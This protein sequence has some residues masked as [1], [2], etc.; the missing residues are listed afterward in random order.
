M[1]TFACWCAILASALGLAQAQDVAPPPEP[2]HFHLGADVFY[3]DLSRL[4]GINLHQAGG[5]GIVGHFRLHDYY[6]LE[7]RLSGFAASETREIETEDGRH[8]KNDVTIVAMPLEADAVVRF[9]IG[10]RLCAY[11]GPGIG[12]YLFDG[13]SNSDL[14]TEKIVY[15]IEVDDE[16]GWYLLAGLRAKISRNFDLFVEGRY[17]WIKTSIEKAVEVRN[18]I[19]IDWVAQELDFSGFAVAV[20]MIFSF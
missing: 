9:P 19:G 17:T 7:L 13:Q 18:D 8:V 20:G 3:W 5:G 2:S 1:K 11:G 16:G 6:A 14:G 10:D 15:D 4:D 12:Y